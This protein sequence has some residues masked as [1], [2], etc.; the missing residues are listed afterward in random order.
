MEK[1]ALLRHGSG[2]C[3]QIVRHSGASRNLTF[4]GYALAAG[5]DLTCRPQKCYITPQQS[6]ASRASGG[7]SGKPG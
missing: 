7:S 3:C 1:C 2:A 4:P 6:H 5:F